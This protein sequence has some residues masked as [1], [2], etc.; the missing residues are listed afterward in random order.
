MLLSRFFIYDFSQAE[1]KNKKNSYVH[2]I[3][4]VISEEF[5]AESGN[6]ENIGLEID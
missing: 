1:K 3:L 2:S 4:E 6:H 5:E